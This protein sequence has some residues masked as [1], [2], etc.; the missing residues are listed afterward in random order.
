MWKFE[1]LVEDCTPEEA[2]TVMDERLYPDE[3]YGFEYLIKRW[4]MI[5]EEKNQYTYLV[6]IE[7]CRVDQAEKVMLERFFPEEDYGFEYGIARWGLVE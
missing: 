5:S 3:D 2:E 6:E 7:D 4:K 1:V